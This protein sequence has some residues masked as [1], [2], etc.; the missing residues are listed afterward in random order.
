MGFLKNIKESINDKSSFNVD[1]IALLTS[2]FIGFIIGIVICFCLIYDVVTNGYIKTDLIDLGIFLL[3]SGGYIAG[4]GIP[5]TVIDSRLKGKFTMADAM[6]EE[7][8]ADMRAERRKKR[9]EEYGAK[10]AEE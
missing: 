1:A 2:T 8:I 6:H 9:E 10:E 7:D 5:K 4:S 3:C